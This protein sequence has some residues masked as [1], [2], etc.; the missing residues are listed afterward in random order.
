M[1]KE[2]GD[3]SLYKVIDFISIGS[4]I[5]T[6]TNRF[7]WIELET[8]SGIVKFS[9]S[10]DMLKLS[11]DY[12][13]EITLTL[14]MREVYDFDDHGRIYEISQG[15]DMTVVEYKKFSDNFLNSKLLTRHLAIRTKIPV[16]KIETWRSQHYSEDEKRK[17]S[18]WDLYV[19]DALK[20][21]CSGKADILF[22]FD[23]TKEG[24]VSKVLRKESA[25][26]FNG[27]KTAGDK[28]ITLAYNC[29]VQ[30]MDD[31]KF[32]LYGNK[33]LLAGLPWFFQIW[34]RDEAISLKSLIEL[35]QLDYVKEI[36]D[37][38]ISKINGTGR[39]QNRTP[40]SGLETADGTG[41][42]FKRYHEL[43]IACKA[44]ALEQYFSKH[45]LEGLRLRLKQSIEL[46]WKGAKDFLITNKP[47]ETWMDTSYGDD[48]RD[49]ARI[50][51]QALWLAMLSFSNYLNRELGIKEDYDFIE[52]ESRKKI[53]EVFFTGDSLKD[54]ANDPTIRPNVFLSHYIYPD[55][56][57]AEEWEKAFDT[58]ID[59]LWLEWGGFST[60]DKSSPLFQADYTGEDNKSYHRGDSWFFMNNLAAI[61]MYKVNKGKYKDK[62]LKILEASTQDMLYGGIA[63]RPSELSCASRQTAEASL[64]QLW[65]AAT[66]I[67]LVDACKEL[68][69]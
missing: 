66:Y 22:A 8:A 29:A 42:V 4:E 7:D 55:L 54:G 20:F 58:C 69:R 23:E 32:D 44:K 38:R 36:L 16:E 1:K 63:G 64:F 53:K 56:L 15:K 14:D 28:E 49:G 68:L 34:T 25:K 67:E 46:Q 61:S 12:K 47:L 35:G 18:P 10:Q 31:L 6:M 57:S 3:W 39:I 51:I 13:G 43:I 65:S 62:V 19:F 48:T 40:I 17:S 11:C 60:I 2:N 45:D 27:Y 33:G 21:R 9:L 50:E 52:K 37:E 5:K 59:R 41:W 26:R 30:S 24:A